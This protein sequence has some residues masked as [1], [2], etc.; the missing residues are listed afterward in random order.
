MVTRELR[1]VSVRLLLI[2]VIEKNRNR[3]SVAN[4]VAVLCYLNPKYENGGKNE[5]ENL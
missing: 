1:L 3:F 2:D 4:F 5:N